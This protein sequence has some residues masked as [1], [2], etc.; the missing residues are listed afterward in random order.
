VRAFASLQ[1]SNPVD[2]AYLPGADRLFIAEQG[3]RLWSFDTRRPQAP[4]ELAFDFREHHRPF[5]NVLGFTFH[6]GFA[7]NRFLFV[8]YNEPGGRQDG[9]YVSR[10]TFSSLNPAVLDPASERVIIRWLSGGHN[11]CT[12]AFGNDGM[13]YIST[14]DADDPDP[15]DGKRKTGQD[16]SDLLGSILRIDVDRVNGTTN[17][18]VPSDNPFLKLPGARPEIWAFG[19]RNPWRMSFDRATGDLWAG[20]VGWEQWEMVYR[21][22]RGGNYGW[23]IA[24]GPNQNVRT[25]VKPGPGPI[26][27]P[28]HAVS[29]SEG[30]SITGGYVYH[31][32][33]LPGLRGAYVYGDWETGKFWALRHDGDRLVSNDELCDT[34]LKPVSFA[35]D[36]AGELLVLD[37]N[38]GLYRLVPNTAPAANESFPRRLSETGLFTSLNP[39][40]P[41]PGTV[42]YRIAAPMWND[43]ATA[44]WLLGVPGDGAIAT[45][46]GVGNIAGGTWFF[47]SNTVLARTLTL[48]METGKASSRR[49]IE[50]QLLHW[51][52]QAWSPYTYRWNPAQTD[53]AL[54]GRAGTNDTFTVI[55]RAAPGARRET[56]WRFHSRA[57]CLRCHNAWSGDALTL[58]WLQL[59]AP[60]RIGAP[61]S[62]PALQAAGGAASE[63]HRLQA[64]GVLH[65]TNAPPERDRLALAD[66][67]DPALPPAGRARSWLHVNCAT[68][69]RFGAGGAVTIHLNFDKPPGEL[70]A[71][72]EKPA[73]GDFGLVGA[74]IVAPG[75]AYRSTLF[76]RICT[77]G[78]GHMPQIGPRLADDTG[79]R[80]VFDWIQSMEKKNASRE[81][82]VSA[83]RLLELNAALQEQF[84]RLG[85]EAGVAQ[86]KLVQDILGSMNGA[87]GLL[88]VVSRIGSEARKGA[89]RAGPLDFTF[90]NRVVA[91]ASTH[92]NA[93][94]R[95]L[96][97]RFL[98]PDK[99][100]QTL[101]GDIHPPSILALKG[102]ADRGRASFTGA[103]QCA[104]CHACGG[105]G[106]AFGPDLSGIGRKYSRADLLEHILQPSRFI[107]PEFRTL[108]VTLRDDT[109]L[110]GFVVQSSPGRADSPPPGALSGPGAAS[111]AQAGADEFILRDQSLVE[112]RIRRSEVKESRESTL[113]AMPDGLLAPLTA[114][115]AADLI[116]FLFRSELAVPQPGK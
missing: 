72:D 42:P 50:T 43:H 16:T 49:R 73:R 84:T 14:G 65:V 24:E 26:L 15:P 92:T 67:Y 97:Q 57:E 103:A 94:V 56:P 110:T 21:I 5:D 27:P 41:A 88:D 66:P 1:F 11:G 95:D 69:H 74:R 105:E 53:A 39:L 6:P 35:V 64:L 109:E 87:L 37:Y 100:R 7:T 63:I 114:Q 102:N 44:E 89:R 18:A 101:G 9:A 34:S 106:R 25:D 98:P 70:R 28:L 46:G 80:V 30:A 77:E 83:R 93:L 54:V 8:N 61:D 115:E 68:C 38:G 31:G 55:D 96:F 99:R 107:A 90:R 59:N 45:S 79:A 71:I 75:A 113:S 40:T 116:E 29:H 22:R 51:D 47:P 60:P 76:Y 91:I 23:P 111:A 13:L 82:P 78:A 2:L 86:L 36:P 4:A 58:N 108:L 48:E 62:D 112:H 19:F 12:L 17:Y 85:R 33:R 3:G 10:F 32:T 20:D 104:R 52:G 81:D